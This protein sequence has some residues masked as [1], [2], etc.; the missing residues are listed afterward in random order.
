MTLHETPGQEQ[1]ATGLRHASHQHECEMPLDLLL[2]HASSNQSNSRCAET[3][4]TLEQ[5]EEDLTSSISGSFQ[6]PGPAYWASPAAPLS[7]A[8]KIELQS[9]AMSASVLQLLPTRLPHSQ[10]DDRPQLHILKLQRVQQQQGKG[11][12]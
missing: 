1:A 4:Y 11:V 7:S 8:L 5:A 6:P 3:V 2:P 10:G 9:G 12:M